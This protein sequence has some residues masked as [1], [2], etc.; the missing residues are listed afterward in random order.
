M[1]AANT[2]A[3][4]VGAGLSVDANLPHSVELAAKLNAYLQNQARDNRN[5]DAK[6][7]LALLYFLLGGGDLNSLYEPRTRG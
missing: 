7:Q 6:I 5:A 3:Y 2:I 1:G 4:L